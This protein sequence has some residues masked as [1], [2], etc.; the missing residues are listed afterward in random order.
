MPPRIGSPPSYCRLSAVEYI[1]ADTDEKHVPFR[2]REVEHRPSGIPAVPDTD[3]I[4]AK[5]PHLD[6]VAVGTAA[7]FAPVPRSSGR[8]AD[9]CFQFLDATHE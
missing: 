2:L 1:D 7:G 6:A 9:Q 3:E 5:S 8:S 4:A